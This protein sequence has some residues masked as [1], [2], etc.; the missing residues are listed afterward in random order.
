VSSIAAE[1]VKKTYSSD[2]EKNHTGRRRHRGDR[3][4]PTTSKKTTTD[5]ENVDHGDEQGGDSQ[6]DSGSDDDDAYEPEKPDSLERVNVDFPPMF[7][8]PNDASW[9]DTG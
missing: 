1:N 4:T 9:I 8:G 7:S 5:A 3:Y 2:I 6:S